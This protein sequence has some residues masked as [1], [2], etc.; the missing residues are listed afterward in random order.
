MENICAVDTTL[1]FHNRKWWIFTSIDDTDNI[2][3]GSTELFLYFSDDLFSDDWKSHPNNP[4]VSD[5]RTARPAGRI[6]IRDNKI[7]RPSQ[8]CSVRYGKGFNLN[9]ITVLTETEY[10][11][12]L[13]IKVEPSWDNKLK[14][15]HTFNFD[16]NFTI[17]DAY[18]YR[19]RI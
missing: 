2:S 9:E 15:T 10:E 4:L 5:I 11:E 3:G 8:D 16:K 7:Y 12:E 6:F 1:L 13:L 18:S 17:I 19:R 14:G